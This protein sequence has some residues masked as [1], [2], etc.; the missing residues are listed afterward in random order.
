MHVHGR[1]G[2]ADNGACPARHRGDRAHGRAGRD[3]TSGPKQAKVAVAGRTMVMVRRRVVPVRRRTASSGCMVAAA[4]R[5]DPAN[6]ANGPA[7]ASAWSRWRDGQWGLSV[8]MA[9]GYGCMVGG[10]GSM[11]CTHGQPC[12]T[13]AGGDPGADHWT[14]RPTPGPAAAAWAGGS[15]SGRNSTIASTVVHARLWTRHVAHAS[16]APSGTERSGP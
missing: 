8:R 11:S 9:R 15:C 5:A 3:V 16:S 4:Q 7:D 2:A 13:A 14:A 6:G 1:V 12:T 10:A